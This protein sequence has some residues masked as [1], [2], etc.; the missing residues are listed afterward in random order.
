MTFILGSR[1]SDG[2]IL[3]AD[4]KVT[5]S[6]GEL[7]FDFDRDK[8]FGILSHIVLGSSG[9]TDSFELFRLN[10]MS[11]VRTNVVPIDDIVLKLSELTH[12]INKKYEWR[13]DTD[14][15]VLIA[16]QYKDRMSSLTYVSSNGLPHPVNKYHTSGS[17]S[18]Y[19]KIFLQK[20]WNENMT[21]KQ[22]AEV[23]YFIIKYIEEF[24]LDLSVG[25]GY[26]RPQIWFLPDKY[27]ENEKHEITSRGDTQAY[28]DE[29]IGFES[30]ASQ[31][32]KKHENHL[33]K[34]F[35]YDAF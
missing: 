32:L 21:M 33:K 13:Y 30:R 19:A 34:L 20:I 8:L 22:V 23:G 14:F 29:M 27:E 7:G 5:L 28:E 4:R 10:A 9:S 31:T 15:D 11:Y 3:I 17:G 1:C 24:E 16:M 6:D 35:R 25:V 2:V 12:N 18:K 26:K